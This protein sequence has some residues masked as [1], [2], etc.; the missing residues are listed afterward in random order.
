MRGR[1]TEP[2]TLSLRDPF[3]DFVDVLFR[4]KGVKS[5]MHAFRSLII[6]LTFLII[7][8]YKRKKN[9]KPYYNIWQDPLKYERLIYN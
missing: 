3:S 7:I 5:I 4:I 8:I 9:L 1:G 6:I 2:G